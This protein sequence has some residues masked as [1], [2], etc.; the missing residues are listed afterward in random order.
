MFVKPIQPPI[1]LQALNALHS[2]LVKTCPK[3]EEISG[4]RARRLAGFNGEKK[5]EY[6]L[7]TIDEDYYFIFHDLCLKIGD[8]TFQMDFLLL[9]NRFALII[10]AKNF[11]GTMLFDDHGQFI[12]ILGEQQNG[13]ADPI[14]QAQYHQR[15]LRKWLALHHFPT[16]PIDYVV[17][18]SKPSTIIRMEN[19]DPEVRKRVL[20]ASKLPN[21]LFHLNQQSKKEL[22]DPKTLRKLSK[23][24][25]KKHSPQNPNLLKE[26]N[27]TKKNILPGVQCPKCDSLPMISLKGYWKCPVCLFPSRDAHIHATHDLFLLFGPTIKNQQFREFLLISSIQK[28]RKLLKSMN[29]PYSGDKR[30]RVYFRPE[31]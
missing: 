28:A 5:V 1:R 14:A 24:L 12:R 30:G 31:K 27:L 7:R 26:Y 18:V 25:I 11:A 2:R 15:C 19:P 10:E 21:Y 17:S 13:Y 4:E 3:Y 6:I 16:L 22:F 23:L 20:P 8:L 9:T 29:L